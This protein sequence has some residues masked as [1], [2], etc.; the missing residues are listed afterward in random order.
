M[1][2]NLGQ[3]CL[4]CSAPGRKFIPRAGK[5]AGDRGR[6]YRGKPVSDL[7]IPAQGLAFEPLSTRR[8]RFAFMMRGAQSLPIVY[9]QQ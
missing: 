7:L 2:N 5:C 1:A 4:S 9:V 6:G 8:D 3:I